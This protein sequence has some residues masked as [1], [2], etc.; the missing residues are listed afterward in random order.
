MQKGDAD[1]LM[2]SLYMYIPFL[3]GFG[4]TTGPG[5]MLS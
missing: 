5:S 4:G 3:Y 1:L 2:M